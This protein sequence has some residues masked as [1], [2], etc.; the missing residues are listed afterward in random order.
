MSLSGGSKGKDSRISQNIPELCIPN[1]VSRM[2]G[3]FRWELYGQVRGQG[4]NVKRA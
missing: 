4:S 3:H 2:L 1:W